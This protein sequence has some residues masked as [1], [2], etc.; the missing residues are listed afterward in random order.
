MACRADDIIA[1]IGGDEF[2]I[3]LPKTDTI[4]ALGII[5]RIKESNNSLK[6]NGMML[7]FLRSPT[8]KRGYSKY[9]SVLNMAERKHV[10]RRRFNCKDYRSDHRACSVQLFRN[11]HIERS[12]FASWPY[13]RFN[14]NHLA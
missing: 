4:Q 2:V 10:S 12:F 13:M 5:E 8:R 11:C 3:L 9:G 1:R 14:S 6:I 7:R